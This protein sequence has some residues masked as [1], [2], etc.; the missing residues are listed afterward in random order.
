M[1]RTP[2]RVR[3]VLTASAQAKSAIQLSTNGSIPVDLLTHHT[4]GVTGRNILRTDSLKVWDAGLM[5]RFSVRE[6]MYVQLRG[7]FFNALNHPD[8]GTPVT[9]FS[10]DNFGRV[11]QPAIPRESAR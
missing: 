2:D 3:S 9:N 11:F 10:S 5:R 6:N 7:E 4:H 1:W 8:F